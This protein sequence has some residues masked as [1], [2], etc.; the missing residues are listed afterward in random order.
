MDRLD[1]LLREYARSSGE[2]RHASRVAVRLLRKLRN[3]TKGNLELRYLL[4]DLVESL[5]GEEQTQLNTDLRKFADA[6]RGIEI[7][8]KSRSKRP[9]EED[10]DSDAARQKRQRRSMQDAQLL[11]NYLIPLPL[12]LADKRRPAVASLLEQPGTIEVKSANTPSLSSLFALLEPLSPERGTLAAKKAELGA[13]C[14]QPDILISKSIDTLYELVLLT[15]QLCAPVRDEQA[16]ALIAQ[17]EACRE[18]AATK[19][20]TAEEA[21]TKAMSDT[22]A[23][24][25]DMQRD[26][27]LFKL[28]LTAACNTDEQLVAVIR[29]EAMKREKQA[30]T[31]DSASAYQASKD[32]VVQMLGSN[33]TFDRQNLHRALVEIL[34]KPVP[35]SMQEPDGLPPIF[36]LAVQHLFLL[37]NR[38]QAVTILATLATI[39]PVTSAASDWSERLHTL[40]LSE[41]GAQESSDD[42][43][44]LANVADETVRAVQPDIAQEKEL[45]ASV[46]RMVSLHDPVYK[47]LNSRLKAAFLADVKT[48]DPVKGFQVTPLPAELQEIHVVINS[49]LD[50]ACESWEVPVASDHGEARVSGASIPT[51]C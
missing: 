51:H 32:W 4:D 36:N 25:R 35:V 13:L 10:A 6:L 45:R 41:I 30:L 39:V 15:A 7:P 5:A 11:Y 46:E 40:L 42:T 20:E 14:S 50:W 16:K 2:D 26:I 23:L 18:Y 8:L 29:T 1:Q 31:A 48:V 17:V 33:A 24:L 22:A 21:Y 38:L 28:G 9:K 44:K 3:G 34:F 27:K 43:I 49:I 19:Q 47:L 37:Q 12:P